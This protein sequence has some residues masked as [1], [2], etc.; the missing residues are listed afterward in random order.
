MGML[1]DFIQ[2][3]KER[4]SKSKEMED[5]V[6]IQK[7]IIE[8]QKSANERELERYLEEERQKA[9]KTQIERFREQRKNEHWHSPTAIDTPN[10]FAKKSGSMLNQPSLMRGRSMFLR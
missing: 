7:R 10:M 2:R 1:S 6:R 8:K 3:W 9:I 4:K 5:D